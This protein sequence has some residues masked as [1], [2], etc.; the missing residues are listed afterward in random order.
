MVGA[1]CRGGPFDHQLGLAGADEVVVRQVL[2]HLQVCVCVLDPCADRG[3]GGAVE[4]PTVLCGAPSVFGPGVSFVGVEIGG[5]IDV[6][7]GASDDM[8]FSTLTSGCR[9]S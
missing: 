7:R 1:L 5:G 8:G 3:R 6:R 9:L 2:A 4:E